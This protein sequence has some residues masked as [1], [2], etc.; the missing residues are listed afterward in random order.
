MGYDRGITINSS[1]NGRKTQM[2]MKVEDV[3]RTANDTG[4]EFALIRDSAGY[5][6]DMERWSCR[7]RLDRT[8][9]GERSEISVLAHGRDGG[10]AMLK[11]WGKFVILA[12]NGMKLLELPAP[13]EMTEEYTEQ[14]D[15]AAIDDDIPF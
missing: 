4:V 12:Q 14:Q 6:G 13:E 7:V 15:Q 11:A 5:L 10:T 8:V 3:L 1:N 9:D 2:V